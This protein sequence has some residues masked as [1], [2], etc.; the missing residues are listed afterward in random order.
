[1]LSQGPRNNDEIYFGILGDIAEASIIALDQTDDGDEI[2]YLNVNFN[3]VPE[4][5]SGLIALSGLL[6]VSFF[7]WARRH[8][9]RPSAPV[10]VPLEAR[11]INHVTS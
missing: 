5:S 1:M 2:E 3:T 9:G 6:A 11:S 7:V 4:P 8:T 10:P